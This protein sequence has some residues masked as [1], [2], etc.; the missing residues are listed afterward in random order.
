VR[1]RLREIRRDGACNSVDLSERFAVEVG[2]W[3]SCVGVFWT[4]R[5][6]PEHE[7]GGSRALCSRSPIGD[8]YATHTVGGVDES[9]CVLSA[10]GSR[11]SEVR[12]HLQSVSE[13]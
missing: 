11:E 4:G 1:H 7:R 10:W 12:S 2:A 9:V 6:V 13:L 8:L 5:Q 3:A